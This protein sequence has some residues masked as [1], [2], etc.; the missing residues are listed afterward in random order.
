MINQAKIQSARK[1]QLT[2]V[3]DRLGLSWQ[4]DASYR[5]RRN[6]DTRLIVVDTRYE[7]TVTGHLFVLRRRGCRK[8]VASGGG[9]IDLVMSLTGST[10]RDAVRT[11]A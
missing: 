6:P 7:M 4:F 9:A 5:P 10:F 2:D 3:L 11:L 1:V 8:V